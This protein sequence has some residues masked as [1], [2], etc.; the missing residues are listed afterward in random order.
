M[1]YTSNYNN[2]IFLLYLSIPICIGSKIIF[3]ETYLFDSLLLIIIYLIII[4]FISYYII[5]KY[6]YYI[7]LS[8]DK[9]TIKYAFKKSVKTHFISEIDKAT[10]SIT[11]GNTP[12]VVLNFNDKTNTSFTC[13]DRNDLKKIYEYFV[14]KKINIV[15]TPKERMNNFV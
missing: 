15:V 7:D 13:T 2:I 1:K 4:F 5:K 12:N 11:T 6:V 8:N 14:L 10:I 9:V 3:N